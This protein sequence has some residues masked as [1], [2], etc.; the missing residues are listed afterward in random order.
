[1]WTVKRQEQI[2]VQSQEKLIEM[3]MPHFEQELQLGF[4]VS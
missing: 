4:L 1:M 3:A 2:F